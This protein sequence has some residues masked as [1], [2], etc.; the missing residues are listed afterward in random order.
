MRKL[1]VLSP[2]ADDAEIG[3]G[4]FIART[5]A[6]GGEVMVCVATVSPVHFLHLGRTVSIQERLDEFDNSMS[7]LGVQ[8]RVILSYERD[9]SMALFSQAEMVRQLDDIQQEF[10]PD[11]V[12]I[13]LPSS[14]QDHRYCWEVG[15]AA[16]RPSQAKHQ[17]GVIAAYEYPSTNWGDG[18]EAN[19]S[20]GGM[21]ANVSDYW[22]QKVES[23]KQYK[24]QMRADGHLF[25][26]DGVEALARLRGLESG[27]KHAELFHTLRIRL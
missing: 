9:G 11:T 22:D 14:H 17:P 13:P 23:L 6:E 3:C 8:R 24:T 26:I 7:V 18:A 16:T 10:K 21:Y 27:Y 2:H 5:V 15:I 25:S 19:A 4:G 12:L 20:R 1:L